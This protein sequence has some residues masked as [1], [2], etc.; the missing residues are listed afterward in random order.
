MVPG[1]E[2]RR[3][4]AR[5]RNGGGAS[6]KQDAGSQPAPRPESREAKF[7][8]SELGADLGLIFS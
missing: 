7:L 8:G 3:F 5:G 6:R 2:G 1:V 4:R